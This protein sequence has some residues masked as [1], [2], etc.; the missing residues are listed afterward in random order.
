MSRW[1]NG[2]AIAEPSDDAIAG[3]Q[4]E[5]ASAEGL[6]AEDVSVLTVAADKQLADRMWLDSGES[7]VLLLTS[8]G[9]KDPEF[10][11]TLAALDAA[12]PARMWK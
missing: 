11:P 7:V 3:M 8:T 10:E 4:L 12:L 6:Y 5:L 2:S 9:L 1:A